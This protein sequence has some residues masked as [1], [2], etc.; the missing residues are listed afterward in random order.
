MDGGFGR[1]VFNEVRR[2]GEENQATGIAPCAVV[3]CG[4]LTALT[5][6]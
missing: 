2:D 5:A 6:L 4:E 3:I 1:G